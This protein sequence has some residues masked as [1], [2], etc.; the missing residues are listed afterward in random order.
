MQNIISFLNRYKYTLLFLV[1]QFIAFNLTI[2]SH[3]YHK[4]KWFNSANY[5]TGFIYEKFN[6]LQN[7]SNLIKQNNSLNKENATLKNLLNNRNKKG[8]TQSNIFFDSLIYHQKY[9]YKPA[10]IID[11]N[12]IK[13]NNYLTINIGEKDSITKNKGVINSKGI[14]GII[15]NTTA[16]YARVMSILNQ[17]SRINAKLKNSGYYGT[18][19]WNGK[20]YN[21]VQLEDIPRQAIIKIGDSIVTGGK[22]SIFPKGIPIGTVEKLSYENNDYKNIDIKLFN[23]MSA[24][25][26]VQVITNFHENEIK[27]VENENE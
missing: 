21:I 18:L 23:D 6:I 15:T 25:Q 27:L 13:S 19:K 24:I 8:L 26:Y 17:N 5:I 14:V 3:S 10:R 12:Y 20:N 11:N 7:Y 1:L 9:N 16:N 22:S 4:S 2:Q